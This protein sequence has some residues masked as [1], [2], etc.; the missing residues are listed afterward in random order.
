MDHRA[1]YKKTGESTLLTVI[2]ELEP[3]GPA[4]VL[5]YVP[6]LIFGENTTYG[7]NTPATREKNLILGGFVPTSL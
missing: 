5:R 6:L 2:G 3:S 4:V 7:V 1:D